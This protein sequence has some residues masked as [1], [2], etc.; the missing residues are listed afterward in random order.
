DLPGIMMSS[1]ALRLIHLYAV[2]PG[3]KGVVLCGNWDGYSCA[4]ALVEAGVE[5]QTLVDLRAKPKVSHPLLEKVEALG[6]RIRFQ[7]FVSQALVSSQGHHLA[8]VEVRQFDSADASSGILLGCDLLVMA[9]GYTPAY[10]LACQAGGLLSYDETAATFVVNNLP[11]DCHIAGSM[12]GVWKLDNVIADGA[13]A[14]QRALSGLDMRGNEVSIRAYEEE[15]SPNFSWPIFPH[16]RGMEFVDFDED[17][18][19]EDIINA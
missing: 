14:A 12:N 15:Q 8:A 11:H 10:Q 13:A 19:V 17:L 2:R 18:Q 6:I 3:R 16:K 1:A 9:V 7:Q 4:L 5:V